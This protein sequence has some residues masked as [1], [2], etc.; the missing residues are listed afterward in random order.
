MDTI[1]S[2]WVANG[3]EPPTLF[4][5]VDIVAPAVIS[6]LT[7]P[8]HDNGLP[9]TSP[10]KLNDDNDVYTAVSSGLE[11]LPGLFTAIGYYIGEN[12]SGADGE[13]ANES[14]LG[15]SSLDGFL[16][17]GFGVVTALATST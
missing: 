17:A 5:W 12:Y 16:G 15:V 8:A 1:S 9:F 6:A 4:T 14:M 7:V 3:A 10:I 13:A 2:T 11:A